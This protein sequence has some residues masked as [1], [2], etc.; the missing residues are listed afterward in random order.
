MPLAP[1]NVAFAPRPFFPRSAWAL[2]LVLVALAATQA[3]AAPPPAPAAPLR[4]ILAVAAPG[5][6]P[7]APIAAAPEGI[8]ELGWR[9]RRRVDRVAELERL[10]K[11]ALAPAEAVLRPLVRSGDLRVLA[12]YPAFGQLAISASPQLLPRLR[13]LPGLVGLWP[14]EE[15]RL[16]S[17]ERAPGG[18]ARSR[19]AADVITS[20]AALPVAAPQAGHLARIGAPQAWQRLGVLGEGL[21]IGFI[22][23]GVD[24]SHPL[25]QGAF[26]GRRERRLDR[27]WQDLTPERSRLPV[28]GN[29]HGTHVAGLAL[30]SDGQ[31]AVGAAPGARWVAVR[32]FDAEGKAD[33]LGLLAA[34]DWMLQPGSPGGLPPDPAA[35]P[36]LLNLSWTLENGADDRFRPAL[37]ALH[38]AEILVL[39]AA[40]NL[41]E[42]REAWPRLLAPASY[43][44][45]FAVGALDRADR[46]WIFG[47]AGPGFWGGP[48]PALLAPGEDIWSSLP[49]GGLGPISGSSM[50]TPLATGAA[51]VLWGQTPWLRTAELAALLMAGAGD[52]GPPGPDADSGFGRLNLDASLD[53]ALHAGRLEGRLSQAVEG[54]PAADGA[55]L[56][57][58]RLR[59]R[60]EGWPPAWEAA[61]GQGWSDATGAF[62]LLTPAGALRLTV[63]QPLTEPLAMPVAVRAGQ[64]SPLAL[65]L[66]KAPDLPFS[67]RLRGS[68]DAPLHDTRLS[69]AAAQAPAATLSP[70][71]TV[72]RPPVD[73]EGRFEGRLPAGR[74]L[75]KAEA[76]GHRTLTATLELPL[77]PAAPLDL[78]LQ[79]A[80]RIL[81]VGADAWDGEAIGPYLERPLLDLGLPHARLDLLAPQDL[82]PADRLDETDLLWWAHVYQS[83]GRMD[84]LRGD[85]GATD[86]LRAY[87]AEGGDLLL[88]GQDLALW[89]QKRG[90]ARDL[91]SEAVGLGQSRDRGLQEGGALRGEGPLA[92]LALNA[93]WAG[94]AAKLRYFQP[95][96]LEADPNPSA[97]VEAPLRWTDGSPA[98]LAREG[99][100]F[101][102]RRTLLGFGPE[103][104]GGRQALARTL[105]T[106]VRPALPADLALA[107]R[108]VDIAPGQALALGLRL[109]GGG[110]SRDASLT[111]RLPPGLDLLDAGGLA[112]GGRPD[113]RV[114]QGRLQP[115][116]E[117]EFPLRLALGR[118]LAA[119]RPLT[120]TARLD[121]GGRVRQTAAR[122]RPRLPELVLDAFAADPGRLALAGGPAELRLALRNAGP[123]EA[124]GADIAIAIPAGLTVAPDSLRA[125]WGR[126]AMEA[127]PPRLR[128]QG[129]LPPGAGL[130]LAWTATAPPGRAQPVWEAE[131]LL[132]GQEPRRWSAWQQVGGPNLAM[133]LLPGAPEGLAAGQT[134]DLAL[135]LANPGDEAALAHLTLQPL[136]ADAAGWE[137]LDPPRGFWQGQLTPGAALTL[138]LRLRVPAAP[139]GADA[140]LRLLLEDDLLP[141]RPLSQ[142]FPIRLRWPDLGSSTAA[143]T[144]AEAR[145]GDLVWASLLLEN[146]GE[147]PAQALVTDALPPNLVPLPE[148]LSVSAGTVE[149]QPGQ[150]RWTCLVAPGGQETLRYQA[151]AG[152]AAEPNRSLG[153]SLRIEG[154]V[155]PLLLSPGLRLNPWTWYGTLSSD[156][157]AV[158]AGGWVTQVLR[159][160]GEGLSPPRAVLLAVDLPAALAVDPTSLAPGLRLEA[161]GR[162]LRYEGAVDAAGT[163]NL[164]WR[165][166]VNAGLRAGGRLR[167]L[168]KAT[169]AGLPHLELE[170]L[171]PVSSADWSGTGLR[172]DRLLLSPGQE[173]DLT[174]LIR[175]SGPEPQAVSLGMELPPGLAALPKSLVTTGGPPAAWD[176]AARRLRWA[177]DLAPGS[178]LT[179]GL[180][181][182][183]GPLDAEPPAPPSALPPDP[184]LPLNLEVTDGQGLVHQRRLVLSLP[185]QILGFPW[186]QGP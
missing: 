93:A 121:S 58:A 65:T 83:P 144:P 18:E 166:R 30:G 98:A 59:L 117:R 95:D 34:L 89:D 24:G 138:P 174:A 176:E 33:D 146:R 56:V 161:G 96:S 148:T 142:S 158:P 136:G 181:V 114:W 157:A 180:R 149:R 165:S 184:A 150:L 135:G 132:P 61:L 152:G 155:R 51:A 7:L 15:R 19:E 159:L 82:P 183:R 126:L 70:D 78:R 10:G 99:G 40:G 52:L 130:E 164:S 179:I 66:R 53:L 71:G 124:R 120:V 46:S 185:R 63:E 14:V 139:S 43:P 104:G 118:P 125:G 162:S 156:P 85:R 147:E 137:L 153:R 22:D 94:G 105:D 107:P 111:L 182:R 8:E 171:L 17:A 69:L 129:D 175:F 100:A 169:A 122:L 45:A 62:R 80:P 16:P 154:G 141:R 88:S 81:L 109:R 160:R 2:A 79:P 186:L 9:R 55:P 12:R 101:P 32:A 102:G 48:K 39:C 173:T 145:A 92:G 57:G 151:R 163:L 76:A 27:D 38:Q 25:L 87:L 54:D 73:A 77:A 74:W 108:E 113:E 143:F 42:L 3:A 103:S 50:A 86:R 112:A 26:R 133:D 172:A 110:R 127:Q 13:R 37:Q 20:L 41:E 29:G 64:G 72:L 44:E 106:L 31:T 23:S 67:G 140:G 47:R 115:L 91:M 84:Q 6:A 1:A 167:S 21:V 168:A 134:L 5:A 90:L 35:A 97:G 36:D 68:M 170:Q 177:G 60:G 11:A 123:V 178:P 4:L 119:G 116:E 128:W 49:G 75:L 28:D 131:A